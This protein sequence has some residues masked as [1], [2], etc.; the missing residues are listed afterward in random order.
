MTSVP[1]L[2]ELKRALRSPSPELA[3]ES[4]SAGGGGGG[5]PGGGGGAGPPGVPTADAVTEPASPPCK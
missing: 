4:T 3:T 1:L 2:M 5:G